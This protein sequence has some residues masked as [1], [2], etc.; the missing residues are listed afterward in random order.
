MDAVLQPHTLF[1]HAEGAGEEF[2]QPC[3]GLAVHRW[4]LDAYA[5]LVAQRVAEGIL[6]GARL[7]PKREPQC[8]PLPG[9]PAQKGLPVNA[10]SGGSSSISSSTSATM[11]TIGDR[12]MPLMGGSSRCAGSRIGSVRRLSRSTAG[13]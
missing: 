5:Q 3:V 12:S 7:N 2:D 10:R 11:A 9:I 6:P 13:L 1:R 8:L 4:C